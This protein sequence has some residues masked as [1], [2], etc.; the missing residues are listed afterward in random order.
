MG[1]GVGLE[2]LNLRTP[3]GFDY[4]N[5]AETMQRR[6]RFYCVSEGATEESY[7]WGVRN[8][9]TKLNIKNDVYIEIIEK[10]EGQET[11]SHPMQLV[12]ACLV[13]MGHVDENGNQIPQNEWGE[14]C[15]WDNFDAEIDKVCVIF[16]RDYRNLTESLGEI[17]ELC[18]KHG[19]KIVMSN[20]NF[21][22]WLLMHFSGMEQ[23]NPQM[24]LENKKNLRHQLCKDASTSKKY[25]EIL[26]SQKAEGYSKGKKLRFERF[27]PLI[28]TA[29]EQAKLFCEM[30]AQLI[31]ELGTS[32]GKLLEEMMHI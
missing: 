15:K 27:L 17:F 22:L 30:P 11:L 21:E 25:L 10:Q 2:K 13:Q 19:I 32:V 4:T 26:V 5:E 24:L 12:N 31:D 29:I 3:K 23:Y 14:N 9:K 1:E 18:N 8:N 7:F 28:D 6:I 16:D 20:P